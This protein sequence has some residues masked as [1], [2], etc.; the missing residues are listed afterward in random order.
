MHL[1]S[2]RGWYL[3]P[4]N[5]GRWLRFQLHKIRYRKFGMPYKRVRH[6]DLQSVCPKLFNPCCQ[7]LPANNQ[8]NGLIGFCRNHRPG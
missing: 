2:H 7:F 4:A 1:L 5:P 8:N 3:L 6:R